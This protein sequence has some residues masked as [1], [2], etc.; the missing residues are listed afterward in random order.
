MKLTLVKEFGGECRKC[1]YKKCPAALQF[2][3]TDPTLKSFRL[4]HATT[5]SLDRL[6]AEAKKC[7]LICAN[8]H[9]EEHYMKGNQ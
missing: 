5:K 6:R 2:H 7:I 4:S 8:C 1:G 3:H 9:A